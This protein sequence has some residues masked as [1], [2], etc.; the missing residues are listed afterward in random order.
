MPTLEDLAP[1][2]SDSPASEADSPKM[3]TRIPLRLMLL[4]GQIL[5][6]KEIAEKADTLPLPDGLTQSDLA[7]L[8]FEQSLIHPSFKAIA[9]GEKDDRNRE[10]WE[11]RYRKLKTISPSTIKLL[12]EMERPELLKPKDLKKP[13]ESIDRIVALEAEVE[14]IKKSVAELQSTVKSMSLS[15]WTPLQLGPPAGKIN[16]LNHT[17]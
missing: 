12:L 6:S 16:L 14:A 3:K 5:R 8:I 4:Y 9:D 15:G 13:A 2:L 17:Q 7:K 10:Q 1:D 11:S